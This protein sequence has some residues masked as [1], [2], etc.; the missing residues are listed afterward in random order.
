MHLS[1]SLSQ[2]TLSDHTKSRQLKKAHGAAARV[3]G[4]LGEAF[5]PVGHL[6]RGIESTTLK[7]EVLLQ[8][9][10][11]TAIWD[12][13]AL[14]VLGHCCLVVAY[15]ACTVPFSREECAWLHHLI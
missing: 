9:S 3:H 11:S 15:G 14:S 5:A 7:A 2:P 10:G 12:A 6:F 4:A 13:M 8:Q 1:L